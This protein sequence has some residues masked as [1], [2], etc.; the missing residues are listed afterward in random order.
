MVNSKLN[1]ISWLVRVLLTMSLMGCA[2]KYDINPATPSPSVLS[3]TPS[4]GRSGDT[5]IIQGTH[6]A[7][8]ATQN[9]V[10]IGDIQAFVYQS[11]DTYL[12]AIIPDGAVSAPVTV[13]VGGVAST[14]PSFSYIPTGT[15]KVFDQLIP[16]QNDPYIS[17]GITADVNNTIYVARPG[18]HRIDRKITAGKTEFYVGGGDTGRS[19]G[20]SN[21]TGVQVRFNEPTDVAV[22]SKGN[23]FVSDASNHCI[24]KV[25]PAGNVTL[26]AGVFQS[27][28]GKP[29][30]G[31]VDGLRTQAYFAYP[32]GLAID[33]DD[34]LYV[35]DRFNYRIRK[36]TPDNG[37]QIGVVSTIAGSGESGTEDGSALFATFN[38][39]SDLVVDSV[40]NIYVTEEQE[41]PTVRKISNAGIVST[42]IRGYDE[43]YY[44]CA[45]DS[46]RLNS[47]HGIALD[48]QGNLLVSVYVGDRNPESNYVFKILRITPDALISTVAGGGSANN[49]IEGIGEQAYL[50]NDGSLVMIED[51]LYMVTGS[52]LLQIEIN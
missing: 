34:N 14:G 33:K 32:G 52:L 8:L 43:L 44:G 49:G 37:N 9:T 24:R 21:G 10:R 36:I 17:E 23:L 4:C 22:D 2:G 47:A 1:S 6:F 15:V 30:E 5:L 51:L 50:P 38:S 31:Y 16:Y 7:E 19:P 12:R 42:I 41:D 27:Q 45:T 46:Y 35:C 28:L 20:Y 39:P 29:I 13:A 40:G 3:L 26:Y 18:V 48:E 25:D 11:A